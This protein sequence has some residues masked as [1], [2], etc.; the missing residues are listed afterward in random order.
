MIYKDRIKEDEE[1]MQSQPGAEHQSLN[2]AEILNE[3]MLEEAEANTVNNDRGFGIYNEAMLTKPARIIGSEDISVAMDILQ[4]YKIGKERLN[5]RIVNEEEFYMLQYDRRASKDKEKSETPM[6]GWTFNAIHSKHADFMDN[7]PEPVCLP[8]ELSDQEEAKVLTS[9]LPVI[10]EQNDFKDTYSGA[11]WYKLKHGMTAYSVLWNS[12]LENGLGNIDIGRPD[13]LN[14]YWDPSVNDIQDSPHFFSL[15]IVDNNLLKKE[16]PQIEGKLGNNTFDFKRYNHSTADLSN[17]TLVVDWYYKKRINGKT[18]VHYC[19]FVEKNILYASENDER[20]AING[21]YEH[22]EYPFVFDTLF[23]EEGT[24]AG[25][26]IIAIIRDPQVI[27]DIHNKNILEYAK[28]ASKVRWLA[29]EECG[30]NEDEWNDDSV[31]VVH[32]RGANIIDEAFKFIDLPPLSNFILNERDA[33]IDEIKQT[34]AN[35]DFSQGTT[36]AGVTSG[37]AIATLQEAGNKTTRDM[38]ARSYHAYTKICRQMVEL[39]RQFYTEERTFRIT[40]P[41]QTGYEFTSYSNE[42]L[43]PQPIMMNIDGNEM[44]MMG[45]TGEQLVRIPI[46]DID[47]KAQKQSPF[48]TMA[49]NETVMNMYNAGMFEPERAQSASIALELMEFEGKEEALEKVKEGQTLLNMFN[50]VS[51]QLQEANMLISQLTGVP[52]GGAPINASQGGTVPNAMANP[53]GI[54]ADPSKPIDTP[55]ME[56]LREKAKPSVA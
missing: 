51:Q 8:R 30:I 14:L 45:E 23:P 42:G 38:I 46:I 49:L 3:Q 9:I 28:K 20:Y 15:D 27:V 2:T 13:V 17:K 16:F 44:P 48:S 41:N 39:I 53:N 24:P 7:Y 12:E 32:V 40:V 33:K 36:T 34:S 6:S 31:P 52:V 56:T 26:G 29:K 21:Y 54:M 10:L 47:V 35:L 4:K 55:Y 5:A 50:M 19:K 25:F 18:V 11:A 1:Y 37:A 43:Q 22:G